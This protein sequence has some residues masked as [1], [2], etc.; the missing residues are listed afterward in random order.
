MAEDGRDAPFCL[1]YLVNEEKQTARLAA[2]SGVEAGSLPRPPKF[3]SMSPAL[4]CGRWG[5]C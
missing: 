3:L 4:P 1:V 5:R 2:A